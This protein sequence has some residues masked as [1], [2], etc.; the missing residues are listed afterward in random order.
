VSA[1]KG[2]WKRYGEWILLFAGLLVAWIAY[3]V[4]TYRRVAP[5][6]GFRSFEEI[7]SAPDASIRRAKIA[8]GE[9]LVVLGGFISGLKSGPPI[10]VFDRTGTLA[11]WADQTGEGGWPDSLRGKGDPITLDEARAWIRR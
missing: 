9:Y 1:P 6:E 3:E 4:Y 7:A 2:F 11:E 8:D 10:Y 5:R